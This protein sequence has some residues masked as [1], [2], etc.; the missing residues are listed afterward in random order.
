MIISSNRKAS[1]EEF[2]LFLNN[3]N[4]FL[5]ELAEYSVKAVL[6]LAVIV[7]GVFAGIA[8]RKAVN[9]KKENQNSTN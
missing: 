5:N 3:T 6:L 9:K 1:L 4:L 7:A 8:I 2:S